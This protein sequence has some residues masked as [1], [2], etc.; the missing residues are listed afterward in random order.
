MY[1]F[2]YYMNFECVNQEFRVGTHLYIPFA[3]ADDVSIFSSTV[4]GLQ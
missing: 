1:L 3:H 2:I 4:S